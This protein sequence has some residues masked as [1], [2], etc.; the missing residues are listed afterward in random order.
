MTTPPP[1]PLL[2]RGKVREVYDLGEQLLLVA[3][4]RISA[5]DFVLPQAIPRKGE[6]LTQLSRFWFERT[7]HLVQNHYLAGDP[8]RMIA[9]R[10]ELAESQDVWAGRGLLVHKAT[11]F[12][13]ECIVRGYLAGSAWKEYR[14]SGSLAGEKLEEGLRESDRLPGVLFSPSTKAVEGHDE[15]ITFDELKRRLGQK[16]S[17]LL[18]EL[19]LALY[20]FGRDLAARRGIIVADTKFEFGVSDT[21]E[22]LLIDE[23][24]TPD[25]SRFWPADRYEPGRGQESLDKQPVRDYLESLR[26]AGEWDGEAPPPELSGEI[27]SATT[28]RYMDVYRRLTGQEL[29]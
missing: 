15:N 4:D 7:G 23:V 26:E 2:R 18:R 14:E 20:R 24:L 13:V 25:S 10:P 5:F 16:T 11:P 29:S 12:P 21:G 27:V 9:L 28:E 22:V 1:F 8:Q 3:S 6:V 19:S 17:L